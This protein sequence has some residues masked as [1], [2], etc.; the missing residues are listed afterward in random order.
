MHHDKIMSTIFYYLNFECHVN[1]TVYE[2]KIHVD[3]QSC[4]TC[5]DNNEHKKTWLTIM[6]ASEG[7]QNAITGDKMDALQ[8]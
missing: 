3:T 6:L 4:A 1:V 8:L 7:N 2:Y 5:G